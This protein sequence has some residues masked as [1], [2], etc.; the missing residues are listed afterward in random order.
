MQARF[1][2]WGGPLAATFIL[3][4][5]VVIASIIMTDRINDAEEAASFSRLASEADEFAESLEL[6]MSTDRRQLELLRLSLATIWAWARKRSMIFLILTAGPGPF[7]HGWNCC[8]RTAPCS[9]P[10]ALS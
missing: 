9:R 10:T 6:N 5:L 3:V 2:H 1:V 7:S 8:C 4:V